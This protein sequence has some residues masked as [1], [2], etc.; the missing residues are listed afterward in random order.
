MG[1][2]HMVIYST[3]RAAITEALH[4]EPADMRLAA[5]TPSMVAAPVLLNISIAT[6][7]RLD[8]VRL[9]PPRKHLRVFRNTVLIF[10]TG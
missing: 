5:R 10:F 7:T 6:R 3:I 9:L 8:A 2:P 1:R 4:T